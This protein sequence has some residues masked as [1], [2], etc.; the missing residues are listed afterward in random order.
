MLQVLP[1]C[2]PAAEPPGLWSYSLASP[3]HSVSVGG[4]EM[5]LCV[6]VCVSV[7]EQEFSVS[8]HT[9][10]PVLK[11]LPWHFVTSK[12]PSLLIILD[13]LLQSTGP[14]ETYRSCHEPKIEKF[15]WGTSLK[16]CKSANKHL[17]DACLHCSPFCVCELEKE[18][19]LVFFFSFLNEP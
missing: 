14:W 10:H 17:S 9:L 1:W 3:H 15:E 18:P 4:K 6:C 19:F 13:W 8:V 12:H 7:R 11:L 2:K 16:H 5:C